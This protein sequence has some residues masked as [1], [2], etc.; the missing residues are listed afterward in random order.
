[1]ISLLKAAETL[2]R[3]L[4]GRW[5]ALETEARLAAMKLADKIGKALRGK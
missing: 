3:Q 2:L 5:D 1:L 4:G